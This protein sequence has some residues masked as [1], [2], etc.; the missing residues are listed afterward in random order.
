MVRKVPIEVLRHCEVARSAIYHPR[1]KDLARLYGY[2][3]RQLYDAYF[4]WRK[5]RDL[6]TSHE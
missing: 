1:W 3:Q 5:H 6:P 4:Y 2:P